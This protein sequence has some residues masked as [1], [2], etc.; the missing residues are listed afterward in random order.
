MIVDNGIFTQMQTNAWQA[1]SGQCYGLP[2]AV[3]MGDIRSH[4]SKYIDICGWNPKKTHVLCDENT[5]HLM[6]QDIAALYHLNITI[7]PKDV[8]PSMQVI[9]KLVKE[10]RGQ[11]VNAIV[12]V[13]SGTVNDIA[14]MASFMLGGE[15]G[16]VATAP[17][18]NGYLSANA[19]VIDH[20]VRV[21]RSA[22]MP[23]HIWMDINILLEAPAY[24]IASGVGDSLSRTT[25]QADWLLSHVVLNTHYNS[26]IF[27]MQ[28]PYEMHVF[29]HVE[30]LLKGDSNIMIS[31]A[32]LLLLSGYGMTLAG[33]SAPAS[34]GEHMIAHVLDMAGGSAKQRLTHGIQ[35]A[36]TT[37]AMSRIQQKQVEELLDRHITVPDFNS[38]GLEAL[39]SDE[40][41]KA[42]K[43]AYEEKAALFA[44]KGCALVSEANIKAIKQVMLCVDVLEDVAS[45]V[46]LKNKPQ[47]IGWQTKAFNQAIKGARFTRNRWT[48]LDIA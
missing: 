1:A 23:K 6:A 16:I 37:L 40:Q 14:K 22:H 36:V 28:L 39:L 26:D 18:M 20:G 25:A 21:S 10:L 27:E 42:C 41:L 34:G 32:K 33:S 24:L 47:D 4:I 11:N 29:D 43:G 30:K 45:R 19:S 31:L 8:K 44:Q 13:G 5:V 17:S 3:T 35:I 48:F 2:C 9:E 38:Q 15:Y 12:A 46:G 7:L